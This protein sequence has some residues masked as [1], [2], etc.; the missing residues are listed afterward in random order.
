[1]NGSSPSISSMQPQ[2]ATFHLPTPQIY[3]LQPSHH[4]AGKRGSRISDLNG[5][6]DINKNPRGVRRRP[7]CV[8][9]GSVKQKTTDESNELE[10]KDLHLQMFIRKMHF[11]QI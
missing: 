7:I 4:N 5:H 2:S 9:R 6:T 8:V 1:M 11:Q 10:A 3:R